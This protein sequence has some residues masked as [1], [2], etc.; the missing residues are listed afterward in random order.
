MKA[1]FL[2]SAMAIILASCSKN[3]TTSDPAADLAAKSSF[4]TTGDWKVTQYS[5]MGIDAS[6][7]FSAY[8]IQFNSDGT[9]KASTTS[10]SFTGTWV[11]AQPAAS[12]DDSGNNATDDKFSKFTIDVT[13]NKLMDKLSHKWL[14]DK[15]T[16]TEIWLR[17]DNIASN[18]ILRFGK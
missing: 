9:F 5:E 10:D 11:M 3:D 13:G 15:V 16:A 7:D 4:V 17:D 6:S 8:T 2:L 12:V 18:E 1:L 14:I